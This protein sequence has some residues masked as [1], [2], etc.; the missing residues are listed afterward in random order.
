[1]IKEQVVNASL[2]NT[3]RMLRDNLFKPLERMERLNKD[4]ELSTLMR[5]KNSRR[6][7]LPKTGDSM[8]TDHST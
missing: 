6:K 7:V 1:M 5:L 2:Y 3:E 8:S 4:G